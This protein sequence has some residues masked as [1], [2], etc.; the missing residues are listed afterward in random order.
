MK[1]LLILSVLIF[2][3]CGKD[4][5]YKELSI[6]QLKKLYKKDN[7]NYEFFQ[8]LKEYKLNKKDKESIRKLIPEAFINSNKNPNRIGGKLPNYKKYDYLLIPYINKKNEKIVIVKAYF[9]EGKCEN[10]WTLDEWFEIRDGGN[11]M[12]R[13]TISLSKNTTSFIMPNG[14]A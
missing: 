2:F 8:S 13:F 3:S 11:S 9:S 12:I 14:E 1:R 10:L 5:C 4:L 6:N 7:P